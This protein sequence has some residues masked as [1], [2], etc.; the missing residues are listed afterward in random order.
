[1]YLAYIIKLYYILFN[2][3]TYKNYSKN[4]FKILKLLIKK[5]TKLVKVTTY[6]S[7]PKDKDYYKYLI[8]YYYS[9]PKYTIA[10]F[11]LLAIF[12]SLYI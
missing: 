12:Y 7:L 8:T 5:V 10:L 3:I 9:I 1:M 11:N 6:N 2:L 4:K